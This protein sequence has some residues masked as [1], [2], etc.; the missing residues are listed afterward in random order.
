MNVGTRS[1][2]IYLPAEVCEVLP[3]QVSRAKLDK[4]QTT[5][6]INFA[7]L[8]PGKCAESIVEQ[9]LEVLGYVSPPTPMVRYE[10]LVAVVF[11]QANEAQSQF[12]VTVGDDLITVPGRVL[13]VPSIEYKKIEGKPIFRAPSQGSWNLGG[14]QLLEPGQIEKYH[15][16]GIA[17]GRSQ[18]EL[19]SGG[20]S[21]SAS[22]FKETMIRCG[23]NSN[24]SYDLS[25]VQV[26]KDTIVSGLEKWLRD[27]SASIKPPQDSSGPKPD[28]QRSEPKTIPKP[29]LLVIILPSKNDE[30]YNTIKTL[31]DT[32]LGFHTVCVTGESRKFYAEN[33][34]QYNANVVLKI[35]LK[36]GGM[37]HKLAEKPQA[38]GLIDNGT[39]MV[40]GIDVTHPSHGSKEGAPSIFA[41]V[42]SKD[43]HL[44][45]WPVRFGVQKASREEVISDEAKLTEMF[46]ELLEL[47][48]K[49]SN[50]LPENIIIY[51][52]GVSEG[53]Y[54]AV[55]NHELVAVRSACNNLYAGANRAIFPR[56]TFVVVAKRHHTRFY[57]TKSETADK[58][59]N[60]K[61]GTVVDRGI[62]QA[63][64]WDF[65]LQSHSVIPGGIERITEKDSISGKEKKIEKQKPSGTARPAH[66]VVLYDE[67]FAQLPKRKR[68]DELQQIT[69]NMCYL[70]GPATKA[71][72]ICPP[73]YL[74]DKACTRARLYLSD[75][76]RPPTQAEIDK[77]KDKKDE[78][79]EKPEKPEEKEKRE[80]EE[81]RKREEEEKSQLKSYQDR[82]RVHDNLKD[83]MFYI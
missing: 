24:I 5:R 63:Q 61:C 45:Q 17:L 2:P 42:A 77:R 16:L 36:L 80:K 3:G 22:N 75:A 56:I 4:D 83:T 47:W 19:R 81:K 28:T 9:G 72:S 54:S 50:N 10:Y 57:P 20:F 18:T 7:K 27:F 82:I 53:Q 73:V 12:G 13:S 67:V 8:D 32:K 76:F 35:N 30:P 34:E 31:A 37:N 55:L 44:S 33:P 29:F 68:A 41:V 46:S 69:H 11:L 64:T 52:D 79:P 21:K 23:F 70:Y 26:Q 43:K 65:F 14:I 40:V 38:L 78:K 74:A 1:K 66:Y 15:V 49:G 71:I 58:M 25:T 59:K 51:R 39:T 60:V 48:K 6:M 62:T